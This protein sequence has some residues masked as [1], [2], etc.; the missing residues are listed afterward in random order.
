MASIY[1]GTTPTLTILC[2]FDVASC[3]ELWVTFVQNKMEMTKGLSDIEY[4]K[5]TITIK[6]TQ[7]E[8]LMFDDTAGV[9]YVQIRG[10]DTHGNAFATNISYFD[11]NRILKEGVIG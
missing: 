9:A 6:F 4:D 7:E 2:D 5:K 11:V 1:R 8:T 10:I 3:A